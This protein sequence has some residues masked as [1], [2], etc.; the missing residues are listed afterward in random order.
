MTFSHEPHQPK[1]IAKKE[2]A[3]GPEAGHW[4]G[5]AMV[6]IMIDHCGDDHK[7]DGAVLPVVTAPV[8]RGADGVDAMA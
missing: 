6:K 4:Q 3:S 8:G 1:S 7:H 2:Q 5:H